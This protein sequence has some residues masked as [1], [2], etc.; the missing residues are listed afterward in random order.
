MFAL[1]L[2]RL[3]CVRSLDKAV[4]EVKFRMSRYS[5]TPNMMCAAA[6]FATPLDAQLTL[7]LQL[8]RIV[9]PQEMPLHSTIVAMHDSPC[10]LRAQLG[11]YMALA[12]EQKLTFPLGGPAAQAAFEAGLAGFEAK[13]FRGLGIMTSTPVRSPHRTRDRF[14]FFFFSMARQ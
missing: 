1:L 11:L 8:G 2:T 13:S 6:P 4:E 14:I 3:S 7:H 12:P 5:V 9:P 10:P